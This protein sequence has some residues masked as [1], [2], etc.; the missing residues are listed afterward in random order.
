MKALSVVRSCCACFVAMMNFS[1]AAMAA[2]PCVTGG[3]CC[4]GN[5]CGTLDQFRH[6]ADVACLGAEALDNPSTAESI[7]TAGDCLAAK[8]MAS[9]V[10]AAIKAHEHAVEAQ[11]KLRNVLESHPD[12]LEFQFQAVMPKIEK[13]NAALPEVLRELPAIEDRYRA[14]TARMGGYLNRKR[15]LAGYTDYRF[16]AAGNQI[17]VTLLQGPIATDQVHFR[18]QEIQRNFENNI[19]PLRQQVIDLKRLCDGFSNEEQLQ[20]ICKA[21]AARMS[22]FKRNFDELSQKLTQLEANY[23]AERRSQQQIIDASDGIP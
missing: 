5:V 6:N 19:A 20:S 13:F 15:Q 17:S 10:E 9:R 23:E 8:I 18:A 22:E 16:A 4:V 21:N 14:I 12:A 11:Q 2:G 1:G 3:V 7:R